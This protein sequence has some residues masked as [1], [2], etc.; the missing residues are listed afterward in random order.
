MAISRV[1]KNRIRSAKNIGQITKAMQAVSAVKMRKSEEFAIL[2][3]PYAISALNIL[4]NIS[5][6]S[7]DE[8]M[9]SLPL[10]AKRQV[11]KTMVVIIS[12]D[13]GLAGS[14]NNNVFK[15]AD[16]VIS[17]ISNEK[18][19]LLVGKK[20][21]SYYTKKKVNIIADFIQTGDFVNV[22]ETR[23]VSDVILECF[24]KYECDE[25]VIIYT[26][27]ISALKQDVISRKILPFTKSNLEN[28]VNSI[29]P[30]RGRYHNIPQSFDTENFYNS[31]V[32]F[33][34]SPKEVLN[35]ILPDLLRIEVHH[36]I[37]EANASEHSARMVAMKSASENALN[38][39]SEL[40][41]SYNK[42]RQA[43]IT[44]ELIEITSGSEALQN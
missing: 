35:R 39:K 3:R 21:K 24:Y 22:S 33:E 8:V 28:I 43:Q 31:F 40:L 6:V 38:L 15:K 9:Y 26:N 14:F 36:A 1:L 18:I 44:K 5:A 4:K 20:A 25:V 12:S 29:A 23:P 37:L 16:K 34:P 42:A 11:N 2:A 19:Y 27:F 32:I 10:L 17:E 13:K 30:L 7:S 41:V